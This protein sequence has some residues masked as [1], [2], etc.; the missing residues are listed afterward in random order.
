MPG[1]LSKL[2]A[3]IVYKSPEIIAPSFVYPNNNHYCQH[4]I[5][6]QRVKP[7][8]EKDLTLVSSF[9]VKNP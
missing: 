9:I 7:Y 4:G 3:L 1:S 6:R 5:G 2:V 8:K